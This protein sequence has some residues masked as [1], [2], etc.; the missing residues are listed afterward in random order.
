MRP[1]MNPEALSD[2]IS[3]VYEAAADLSLWP[4]LLEQLAVLL[5]PEDASMA[6]ALAMSSA[7][8]QSPASAMGE[9][10]TRCLVPH[11]ERA[12]SL[13]RELDNTLY[14][15]DGLE[16]VFDR[17]P[18]G[19][20]VVD[21]QG[22]V[23]SVN[24]A[25][26]SL[27]RASGPL[28]LQGHRL[29][30]TDGERWQ[31][32]LAQ[33]LSPLN[34]QPDLALRLGETGPA[35]GP[36]DVS[37]WLQRLQ[38]TPGAHRDGEPMALVVAAARSSSRALSA[39]ALTA[40]FGLSPAEARLAQQLALGLNLEE[41]CNA[42]DIR[43]NTAKT[44]L[45]RIFVKTGVRRQSELVQAIYASPLWLASS[46]HG[47]HAAPAPPLPGEA[48]SSSLDN[49]RLRLDDGRILSFSDVGDPQGLPL[50]FMHGLGGSRHLR[51]PDDSLLLRHGVRLIIPERPGCGDSDPQPGRRL[52]HWP[53]DM[54][55]LLH[56]LSLK[57]CVVMGYSA[58]T[59]YAMATALALPEQV[60]AMSLVAAVCPVERLGDMRCYPPLARLNLLLGR[61]A[62]GLLT[63]IVGLM[64]K[65]MRSNPY[66]YVE[67]NMNMTASV[68]DRAAYEDPRLR[69][70]HV[71]G[72]LAGIRRGP[73]D[74]AHDQ[75]LAFGAPWGINPSALS[76]PVQLWH[77]EA[78]PLVDIDGARGLADQIP[79]AQFNAVQG[80]GHFILYSHWN[81]VLAGT[82]AM[83]SADSPVISPS[84]REG[85]SGRV[86]PSRT[87]C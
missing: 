72:L 52:A 38:A 18:L 16:A 50:L 85:E 24:R 20:A 43:T 86:I 9:L 64:T 81:E 78:D 6:D 62:P 25:M 13:H 15:R 83:A 4:R 71:A 19:M 40:M 47:Q 45:K 87:T 77:G 84:I 39:Q 22:Q 69:A 53:H 80:G 44:H 42:L 58:G 73:Q 1:K 36:P 74:L 17:L 7:D 66:R 11:L 2:L 34:Q 60:Q 55:Q 56:H 76:L 57:S 41:A 65:G 33:V 8:A 14:E 12:S 30:S 61:L 27:A 75:S 70:A 54:A 3:L 28:R 51:H 23:R 35:Q 37:V 49:R 67:L 82:C 59:P 31:Q 10:L 68:A 29:V 63:S 32:A 46:D 79:G 21:A 26:Q 5:M 48:A